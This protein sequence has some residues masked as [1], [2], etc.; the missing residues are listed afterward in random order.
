MGAN[1]VRAQL[2]S[3]QIITL[4]CASASNQRPEHGQVGIQVLT[5][6]QLAKGAS[7]YEKDIGIGEGRQREEQS[8]IE[9]Y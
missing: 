2:S 5:N 9:G 3:S 6:E 7:G 8:Y 4:S 1:H